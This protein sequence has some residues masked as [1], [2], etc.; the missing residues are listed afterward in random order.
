[1]KNENFSS[2]C[3]ADLFYCF[4]F[5]SVEVNHMYSNHCL[6][7]KTQIAAQWGTSTFFLSQ[8]PNFL[9]ECSLKS[10]DEKLVFCC[11]YGLFLVRFFR[12]LLSWGVV[13]RFFLP[14]KNLFASTAS[15]RVKCS[16]FTIFFGFSH[17]WCLTEHFNWKR[18]TLQSSRR[19]SCR[20]NTAQL[21]GWERMM[22]MAETQRGCDGKNVLCGGKNH[23]TSI[24]LNGL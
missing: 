11:L 13:S 24:I 17:F 19:F 22:Y 1:M 20:M 16:A 9:Q 10:N 8:T 15:L 7:K 18:A 23:R 21:E 5:Q 2:F 6:K 3:L 12:F 4:S 14:A